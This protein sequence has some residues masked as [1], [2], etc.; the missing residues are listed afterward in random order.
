MGTSVRATLA[1]CAGPRQ[2]GMVPEDYQLEDVALVA[3][4]P[5]TVKAEKHNAVPAVIDAVVDV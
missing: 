4:V 2:P 5:G 1:R 3:L